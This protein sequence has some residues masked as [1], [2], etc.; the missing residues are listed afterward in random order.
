M[1][2]VRPPIVDEGAMAARK[3]KLPMSTAGMARL[4]FA[5]T[6]VA[7]QAVAQNPYKHSTNSCELFASRCK[8]V[9]VFEKLLKKLLQAVAESCK[10][11]QAAATLDS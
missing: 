9:K 7:L 5:Q 8:L 3:S 10:F 2:T 6:A 4:H 1:E 11:L